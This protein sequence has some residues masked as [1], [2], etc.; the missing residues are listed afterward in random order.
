LTYGRASQ[1]HYFFTV[2]LHFNVLHEIVVAR[3][4]VRKCRGHNPELIH[5]SSGGFF[6]GGAAVVAPFKSEFNLKA[7]KTKN[8]NFTEVF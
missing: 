4:D 2:T 7:V 5:F 3:F 1:R 6:G 8:T